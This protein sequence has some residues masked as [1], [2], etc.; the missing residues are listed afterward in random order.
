MGNIGPAIDDRSGKSW[1]EGYGDCLYELQRRSRIPVID[2]SSDTVRQGVVA[3][4]G[5]E[6]F[7][8][9]RRA[10][11]VLAR[12]LRGAKPANVPVDMQMRVQLV[13]NAKSAREI[14]LTLPGTLLLR[15][16]KVID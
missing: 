13:V 2:D 6:S 8:S 7:E 10:A 14:G 4:I 5:E 15:A 16:D 9:F 11:D 3:A 12:I 1:V